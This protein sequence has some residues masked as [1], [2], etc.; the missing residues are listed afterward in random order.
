MSLWHAFVH[1]VTG[2]FRRRRG[3]LLQELFPDITSSSIVD[4]G[5]SRHFW[6]KLDLP[7]DPD[8]ISILNISEDETQAT[9]EGKYAAVKVQRFDGY[10]LPFDDKSVDLVLC[11]S[12]IEHV[13]VTMRGAFAKELDRVGRRVCVQTPAWSFPIE[14]HFVMPFIH[15]LPRRAGFALAHVSVWRLLSRPSKETIRSYWWGTKLLSFADMAELFPGYTKV[16]ERFFGLTKS[17]I[18]V[19]R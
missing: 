16:E 7:I 9:R 5:G 6:E 12:V 14:P 13:P 19:K 8:N 11:N 1:P 4:V 17:I 2:Y 15:W 10:H 3:R 18:M